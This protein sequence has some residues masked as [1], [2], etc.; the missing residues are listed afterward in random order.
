MQVLVTGASGYIGSRLVPRLLAAGHD[1]R[2]LSRDAQRLATAPWRHQVEVVAGDVLEPASLPAAVAGVDLVY[3]LV[4]GLDTAGFEEADE[5]AARATRNAAVAAGV[6]HLVYL[7]GLADG[8][9]ALRLSPHLWSRQQVGRTL[10]ADWRLAVTELRASLVI[11]A[12]SASFEVLRHILNTFPVV[13]DPAWLA[14]PCQPVGID[15]VLDVLIEVG[16]RPDSQHRIVEVVGPDVLAYR[17]LVRVFAEV[18]GRRPPRWLPVPFADAPMAG[19]AARYLTP[20]PRP[21]VQSLVTSVAN[22][23]V[24]GTDEAE[25]LPPDPLPLREAMRRALR[26]ATPPPV[27]A[28]ADPSPLDAPWAGGHTFE[29]RFERD[30]AAP[31]DVLWA[32]VAAIG[33]AQG[34]YGS[35]RLWRVRGALDR[36]LGGPGL[37]RGR[38]QR[39][40]EG[41]PVDSWRVEAVAPRRLE[42]RSEMRLPGEARLVLEVHRRGASSRLVQRTTFTPDGMAGRLYWYAML[43]AHTAAMAWQA[44]GIV[45]A[46]DRKVGA[47]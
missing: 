1:V 9:D 33:G 4:H 5:R 35:T 26:H 34:W 29:D 36:I 23:T 2:C 7:G 27:P 38:P 42:L 10:A 43:P 19:L 46:A 25:Q 20:L 18:S 3:Y 21:L 39:L 41:A 16:R 31:A 8:R 45:R 14:T 24:A 13:P 30:S 6:S 37:R 22:A 12:G 15:D 28:P 44:T 32:T 11:G 47:G 40:R 17:D